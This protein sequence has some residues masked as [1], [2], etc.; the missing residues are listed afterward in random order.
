MSFQNTYFST[1]VSSEWFP[2]E[3]LKDR[4]QFVPIFYVLLPFMSIYLPYMIPQA[5]V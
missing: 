5:L 3:L 1:D 2:K 4:Y